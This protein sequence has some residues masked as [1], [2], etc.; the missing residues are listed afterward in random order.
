MGQFYR[1]SFDRVVC[2]VVL[3]L[4][5]YLSV[6][7]CHTPVLYKKAER[8]ITK[9]MPHDSPRILVFYCQD[10]FEIRMGSPLTRAPNAGW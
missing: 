6:A 4:S 5:V 3:R 1:A 2:D 10:R 7:I 8:R 9:T